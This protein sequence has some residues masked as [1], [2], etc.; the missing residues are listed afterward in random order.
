MIKDEGFRTPSA[1]EPVG[2]LTYYPDS[3]LWAVAARIAFLSAICAVMFASLAPVGWVPRLLFS[4]H[5]EHFAAFYVA[6]LAAVVGLPRTKLFRIAT[7]LALFAAVLELGRM[8]PS[9]HRDW[10]IADWQADFG[11][12]LAAIA[13]MLAERFRNLFAPRDAK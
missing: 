4:R 5:L 6:T 2:R 3:G 1:E 9:Q 13:P 10:G 7:G 12:I 8:L 11:G